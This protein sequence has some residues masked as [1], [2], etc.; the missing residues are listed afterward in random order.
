MR[1]V[2][3]LVMIVGIGLA[4]FA[5]YMVNG[6]VS[7][8][9]VELD[10]ERQ[11]A[12]QAVPTV[13]V[14]AVTRQMK[15]GETLT[16]EDVVLI[17]YAEPHLPEG[18]FRTEEELF[19]EGDEELRVVTR[20]MEINEPVLAIKVTEP[21]DI[22]GITSLLSPGMRAFT[23]S[24]DV[25]SGVSGF[26]RP[27]DRVDVYWSGNLQTA[28]GEN[29]NITQLI[30]A[31]VELIAIDQTSEAN[32]SDAAIARTV[33]VQVSPAN[34]AALTQASATGKLSLALVGAGDTETIA[35]IAI[36]QK[37]LLGVVDAPAVVVEAPAVVEVVEKCYIKQRDAN[38]ARVN[39]DIE[40]PCT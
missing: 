13:A 20:A 35:S 27:G 11:R 25:Q 2:F 32:R 4:G 1:A 37:T 18:V 5:V 31:S 26:L 8:T 28:G 38:G 6:Y 39:T 10:L 15:Y 30:L 17:Q 36:D 12:A 24:V 19:P 23:I 29:A 40:I 22:A 7:E 21:G 9:Q 14:Y 33:T 34:V 3:S 16:V